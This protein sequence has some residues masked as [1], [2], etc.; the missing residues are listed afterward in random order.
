MKRSTIDRSW[1][2]GGAEIATIQARTDRALEQVTERKA[3]EARSRI[4]KEKEQ[5]RNR[6]A[7][8]VLLGKMLPVSYWAELLGF[9]E[10]T[11]RS[12]CKGALNAQWI[13][14][15]WRISEAAMTAFL[16]EE[17]RRHVRK[18]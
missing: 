5:S 6:A 8:P 12:W 16:E 10:D 18:G 1:F 14:N 4:T 11:I 13:R 15:E 17:N 2:E 3:S 9:K 7:R